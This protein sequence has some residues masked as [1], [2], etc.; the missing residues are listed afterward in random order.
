MNIER[1][2]TQFRNALMEAQSIALGYEHAAV[3]PMH[4][5]A[6]ILKQND[7][8][9]GPIL[10]QLGVNISKLER[11]VQAKLDAMAK[12]TGQQGDIGVS[13]AL[14]RLFNMADAASQK[15]QDQ[16]IASDVF[17]LS[18]M[19]KADEPMV[20]VL[21]A[22]GATEDGF[23]QAMDKVRSGDK[24]NSSNESTGSQILERYTIDLTQAAL[25]GKLDPVIGRDA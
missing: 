3:E 17:I 20:Q 10:N 9:V 6:A 15:R 8:S 18:A 19:P 25:Q 4:V 24:V 1:L 21:L 22:A 16:F 5:L 7:G 23:R 11:D 13:R 12:V 14:Q 2:T